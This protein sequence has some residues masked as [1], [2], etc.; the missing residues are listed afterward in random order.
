MIMDE[1]LEF[2]DA[3]SVAHAAGT[4]LLGDVIDLSVTGRD[5]GQSEMYFIITVD[6][7]VVTSGTAGTIQFKLVSDST[8][9][10]ATDGT[11]TEHFVSH[12]FVTD[13]TG[14]DLTAGK[15]AV[16]VKLP[17]SD[18]TTYERYLGVL[19]VVGTTTTSAGAVN[20]FL[21]RDSHRWKAYAAGI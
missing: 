10:I 4:V 8:S 9:S 7:A 6:T 1:S 18:V 12:A 16:C 19:Y 20:A 3:A 2:A 17:S 11:A 21:S 13:D 14:E 15:M 5:I